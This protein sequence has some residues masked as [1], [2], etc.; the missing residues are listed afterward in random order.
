VDARVQTND[1]NTSGTFINQTDGF[2]TLQQVFLN[3]Q[4]LADRGTV[5]APKDPRTHGTKPLFFGQQWGKNVAYFHTDDRSYRDIR[6]KTSANADETKAPRANDPKRTILGVTQLAQLEQGLLAAQ[7]A[8]ITWKFVSVSDPI[9]QLG[10]IGGSLTLTNL[11]SFGAG[12]DG[13]GASSPYAAVS[14]DGGKSWIGGY[15]A[16]RNALLKFIADNKITNVVFMSTDDHQNRV[17]EL[18]YSPT[19]DTENQASYVKVP[20]TFEIVAGPLGATGP[21]LITNHTFAMAQQLANSLATAQAAAGIEPLG[22][23]GYP[24]LKN[25]RRENDAA[26]STNPTAV[27]FYSPDTFNYNTLD[28]STSGTLTVTSYGITATAQNSAQEYNAAT[29]P[30]RPIFSFQITPVA[31]TKPPVTCLLEYA[32]KT[33]PKLFSP[34]TYNLVEVPYTYRYYSA[35]NS[36]LG[37]S[38]TDGHVYYQ[39]ATG[40]M[41][42]VGAYAEWLV[43]AGCK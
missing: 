12:V 18:T 8:G 13:N 28:V 15:R 36:Y 6:I 22:L 34:G 27:D 29:N 37:V 24:G 31:S 25:V 16:E 35:T 1:V 4:P 19:G 43:T 26:A 2:K 17:N 39:D 41:K 42:D 9:D 3:Y 14:S 5:N 32:E 38:A 30:V 10:P 21:D 20:Y 11:P 40:V 23:Q 7:T 33:F